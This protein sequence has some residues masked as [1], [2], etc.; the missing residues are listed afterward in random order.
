VLLAAFPSGFGSD[1]RV[2]VILQDDEA[3]ADLRRVSWRDG[4]GGTHLGREWAV[5][6]G[7]R[8]RIAALAVAAGLCGL[9]AAVP[10][11]ASV[12]PPAGGETTVSG[13]SSLSGITCPTATACVAVGANSDTNTGKGVA[14]NAATGAAKAWS[15]GLAAVDPEAVAC[16]GKTRCLAAGFD[17]IAS[18]KVS[19]AAMKVTGRIALPKNGIVAV[20]AIGCAGSRACYA[21]GFEGTEAASKA[22]LVKLSAAGKILK[23]TTAGGTGFAAIACP[24]S[25]TCFIAEHT[26][27]AELIVPLTNGRLGSGHK[28]P[29]GT[30]VQDMSCYGGKLCYALAGKVR[31]AQARTDEMIPVNARTGRPGKAV[32]LGTLNGDGLDCYSSAQCIVVG[33]TG[34]GSSA[35]AAWV[36]ISKGKAG[37]PV[38]DSSLSEPFAAVGCATSKRCYGV[39]PESADTSTVVKV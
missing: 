8:M 17:A 19:G 28:L 12:A 14:I 26:K 6:T 34:T 18:V 33:F 38:H 25:T 23:T 24:S 10:A 36:V 16:P 29:S 2:T 35:V 9:G 3:S 11:T 22:L 15:G 4:Q 30:Y 1:A 20:G 37:A 5:P 31:G 32:S 21:V 13:V 39:A 7:I 27:T